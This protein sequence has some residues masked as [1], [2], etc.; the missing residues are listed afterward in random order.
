[1]R[2][3]RRSNKDRLR[4][5]CDRLGQASVDV[6]QEVRQYLIDPLQTL[7]RSN[8][9]SRC[10]SCTDITQETT[11]VLL[12]VLS[13]TG[14]VAPDDHVSI[15]LAMIEDIVKD[16]MHYHQRHKAVSIRFW[17]PFKHHETRV[18]TMRQ[19]LCD[20]GSVRK[21]SYIPCDVIVQ[22]ATARM[23]TP[24]PTPTPAPRWTKY[25]RAMS[26]A[27]ETILN[28]IPVVSPL[29]IIPKAVA[30]AAAAFDKSHQNSE[31][32]E[33]LNLFVDDVQSVGNFR[34]LERYDFLWTMDIQPPFKRLTHA[35]SDEQLLNNAEK[36][37]GRG[38]LL[39]N[40]DQSHQAL[41]VGRRLQEKLNTITISFL[42]ICFFL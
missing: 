11:D 13:E 5:A 19:Q 42:G 12:Q 20:V 3:K 17:D 4:L 37:I 10:S 29:S 2:Q 15:R 28:S 31:A 34:H 22:P 27:V 30:V 1:M 41:Q 39:E 14:D 16:L 21:E 7:C 24:T 9:I 33:E 35:A 23:P 40:L 32:R 26:W 25:I 18:Q 8:A 36:A 38:L 6:Q